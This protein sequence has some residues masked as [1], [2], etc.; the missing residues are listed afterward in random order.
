MLSQHACFAAPL[1]ADLLLLS[2]LNQ[3]PFP[4]LEV[5]SALE[6]QRVRFVTAHISR[7]RARYLDFL[8]EAPKRVACAAFFEESLMKFV[9]SVE[10]NR[11]SGVW[12]THRFFPGKDLQVLGWDSVWSFRGCSVH[13]GRDGFSLLLPK[14]SCGGLCCAAAGR[15]GG[16]VDAGSW[17]GA[18]PASSSG[19]GCK[20]YFARGGF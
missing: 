16:C 20:H 5:E 17:S 15:T 2:S 7:K 10:F 13:G 19:C 1:P 14:F 12:G 18:R 6:I 3:T 8:L 11:K 9:G 4:E